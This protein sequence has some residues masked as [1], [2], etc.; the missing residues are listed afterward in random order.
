MP[1]EHVS[2]FVTTFVPHGSLLVA[3]WNYLR[4]IHITAQI[5]CGGPTLTYFNI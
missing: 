1:L 4:G 5:P 2:P 3:M